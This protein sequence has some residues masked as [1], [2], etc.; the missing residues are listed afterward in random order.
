MYSRWVIG[1]GIGLALCF[2]GATAQAHLGDSQSSHFLHGFGHS[3]GN[4]EHAIAMFTV[5]LLA[6]ASGGRA[7]WL[8]P[9]LF[10]AGLLGGAVASTLLSL[11]LLFHIGVVI[12]LIVLGLMLAYASEWNLPAIALAVFALAILFGYSHTSSTNWTM[13]QLDYGLGFLLAA[14]L[15]QGVG[16]AA[17]FVAQWL[18]PITLRVLGLGVTAVGCYFGFVLLA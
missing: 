1:I 2:L 7:L 16:I 3:S 8:L 11:P 5:G 10:A 9:L 18:M 17:G 14:L 6:A 13:A 4:T 12:A 15:L